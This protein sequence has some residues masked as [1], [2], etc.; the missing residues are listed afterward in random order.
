VAAMMV[1]SSGGP[2]LAG[3]NGPLVTT[4]GSSAQFFHNGD[5]FKICDTDSDGDSVYVKFQ[6]GSS[7]SDVRLN[8]S[9]GAPGCVTR[10]YNISEGKKVYYKSCQDDTFRDTC[11]S[12]VVGTA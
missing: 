12:T 6:V 7:D 11:S 4:D 1:L 9:G 8:Y 10:T 3:S 2:A 5:K